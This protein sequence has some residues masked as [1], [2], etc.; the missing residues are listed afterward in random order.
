LNP[1]PEPA[2]VPL[3]SAA[4]HTSCAVIAIHE[5]NDGALAHASSLT[6]GFERIQWVWD[7]NLLVGLRLDLPA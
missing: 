5:G 7:R 2:L 6:I 1:L 3:E 4:P